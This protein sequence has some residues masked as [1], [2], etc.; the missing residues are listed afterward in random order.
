M[1]GSFRNRISSH[2]KSYQDLINHLFD[3]KQLFQKFYIAKVAKFN[4]YYTLIVASQ[5]AQN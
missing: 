3:L 5:R 1:Q 2:I 4:K